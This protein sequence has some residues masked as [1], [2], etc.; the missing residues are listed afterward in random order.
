MIQWCAC[1]KYLILFILWCAH[2]KYIVL[3]CCLVNDSSLRGGF[4]LNFLDDGQGMTQGK[5]VISYFLWTLP[6][7]S[8]FMLLH[9]SMLSLHVL[10]VKGPLPFCD[11]IGGDDLW[12]QKTGLPGLPCSIIYVIVH[13]AILVKHWLVTDRLTHRTIAYHASIASHST[14]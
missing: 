4:L 6:A 9:F 13:L 12:H 11:P 5:V 1:D 3:F 7:Q 8:F 2:G 10:A 14:D